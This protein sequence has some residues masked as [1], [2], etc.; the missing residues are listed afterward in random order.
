[1][2]V[3][4]DF[5]RVLPGILLFLTGLVLL[6]ILVIV[7]LVSF[8]FSFIPVLNGVLQASLELMFLPALL[9]AGG[10]IVILTGV[11]WWSRGWEG[12]FSGI[13]RTRAMKD[14][15]NLPERIG[16]FIGVAVS[17]IIFLFFYEN[18]LRGAAFFTADFG[19]AEQFFFYG[20]LIVGAALWLAIALSGRRNE[21]RPFTSLNA[22]FM[23]VAAFRLLSV[24]PFD[25]THFADMFPSSIQFVFGWLTNDIGR[26]LIA[27]AGVL[28]IINFVVTAFLYFAVKGQ[29]LRPQEHA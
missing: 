17:L 7:A 15:L 18:Q 5:G 8:I 23:A 21:V 14:R 19:I 26:L 3:R 9:M 24:F 25:F 2:R 11:S 12:W 13:A 1:M 20:P 22:L 6:V 4:V 29:L 27:V 16:E 10:V 28:S